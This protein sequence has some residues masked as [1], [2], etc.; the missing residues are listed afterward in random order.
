MRNLIKPTFEDEKDKEFEEKVRKVVSKEISDRAKQDEIKSKVEDIKRV[1]QSKTEKEKSFCPE[2]HEHILNISGSEAVCT[3]P[4]CGQK[5]LLQR[6]G[7][8][9]RKDYICTT[10]GHTMTKSEIE[11]YKDGKCPFCNVGEHVININWNNIHKI[12]KNI[13]RR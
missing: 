10:C 2:C 11:Q 6:K 5:F 9:I 12:E 8:N 13:K 4:N 3:G 7:S 1:I